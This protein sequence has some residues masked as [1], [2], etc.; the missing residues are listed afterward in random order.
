MLISRKKQVLIP[1]GKKHSFSLNK[2]DNNLVPYFL[3][4]QFY[5]CF[6][7]ISILEY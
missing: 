7:S 5:S 2:F 3:I 6:L 4:I 1:V